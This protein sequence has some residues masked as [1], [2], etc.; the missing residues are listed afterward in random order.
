[1]LPYS[2]RE[3]GE[4]GIDSDIDVLLLASSDADAEAWEPQIDRFEDHVRQWSG[5][6][7]RCVVFTVERARGLARDEE[8]IVA[9][10][11]TDGVVLAGEP[12]P[13]TLDIKGTRSKVNSRRV[14]DASDR[15]PSLIS[16]R[17]G[18]SA[19]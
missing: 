19:R 15:E 6:R 1:M 9:N 3:R 14:V 2:D 13:S 16:G 4:A 11:M 18:S 12:L 8:L 7:C 5:N 17:A 10:W